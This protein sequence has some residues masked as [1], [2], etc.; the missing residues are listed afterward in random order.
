[1]S[2]LFNLSRLRPNVTHFFMS[3]LP[4][5]I[6]LLAMFLVLIWILR[7]AGAD[8]GIH[9][10]IND[11]EHISKQISIDWTQRIWSSPSFWTSFFLFIAAFAINVFSNRRRSVH[12]YATRVGTWDVAKAYVIALLIYVVFLVA[13]VTG[14]HFEYSDDV[15]IRIGLG[16]VAASIL[17]LFMIEGLLFLMR[18][19]DRLLNRLADL[20]GKSGTSRWISGTAKGLLEGKTANM[21]VVYPVF[22]A[23]LIMVGWYKIIPAIALFSLIIT[24]FVVLQIFFS[25]PLNWRYAAI[26]FFGFALFGPQIVGPGGEP[27]YK[28]TYAGIVNGR[29][30]DHYETPLTLGVSSPDQCSA[31]AGFEPVNVVK[32]LDAWHA[33]YATEMPG[34]PAPKLVIVATSGGAYRSA[35]WTAMVLDK[36]AEE[37]G[38][39]GALPGMAQSIRLLT[40]ASGGMVGAG[41]FS[42]LADEDFDFPLR[43]S[44]EAAIDQD[45]F[46]FQEPDFQAAG[47]YPDPAVARLTTRFPVPGDSLSPIAQMLLQKDI[48]S[49]IMPWRQSLDRGKVLEWQWGTM[50]TSFA[51]LAPGEE[52]GWRPSLIISPTIVETGQPLLI[53][54]LDLSF[55]GHSQRKSAR[56]RR[57]PVQEAE[58]FF[59]LFP[60]A[61]ETFEVATAVRMNAAFPFVSPAASLPTRPPRR[62]VDAGYYDNYGVSLVA[63]YLSD[64][65][66]REWIKAHTSGVVIL[67][68]RAFPQGTET[69]QTCQEAEDAAID[70]LQPVGLFSTGAGTQPDDAM[71][72]G[73]HPMSWLTSPVEAAVSARRATMVF[74]NAQELRRVAL[75]YDRGFVKSFVFVNT[76]E[77]VSLN[78]YLP[79]DER[80]EMRK[81]FENQWE[82][83]LRVLEPEWVETG[84]VAMR[85][86]TFG[87]TEESDVGSEEKPALPPRV[88]GAEPQFREVEGIV[89]TPGIEY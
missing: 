6:C 44:V 70:A 5:N 68:L 17:A 46:A 76:V 69:E 45:V 41:Y 37:S 29:G 55:R 78:W 64:R 11:S 19:L 30:G 12:T 87:V 2:G 89:K 10:L 53:T 62:V 40:G 59:D 18:F 4:Q 88:P 21:M 28:L 7:G 66:I 43:G 56:S 13:W 32:S 20:K 50:R 51:E 36:I 86:V 15:A 38:R 75:L 54:N 16:L 34:A 42:A 82:T 71:K 1:M 24:T 33:R 61:H 27:G 47:N 65:T 23:M 48:P 74:R 14:P 31:Q 77:D 35:Y 26:L 8:Y 52:A 81:C 22:L 60:C 67:Q 85:S 79:S 80:R 73:L 83:N 84:P 72:A 9:N 57:T 63:A 58:K 25:V 49:I 3:I 39:D